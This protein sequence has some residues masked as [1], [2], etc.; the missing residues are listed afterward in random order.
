M[1][2]KYG[3]CL[4]RLVKVCRNTMNSNHVEYLYVHRNLLNSYIPYISY[5]TENSNSL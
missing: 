5:I 3:M 4:C 2:V 1:W